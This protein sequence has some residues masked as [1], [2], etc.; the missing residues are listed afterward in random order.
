M[1]PLKI[2]VT[3][4]CVF[5]F[6]ASFSQTIGPEKGKLIIVGGGDTEKITPYFI[7]QAGGENAKIVVIPT[8]SEEE[9]FNDDWYF[10][11]ELKSAGAKNVT[12]VHTRDPKEADTKEFVKPITE[13]TGVWFTGGRQ[14][15]LVDA[16]AG[17]KVVDELWKLL[18]R[19]GII[20]G[21]SAGATIQGSYLARGDSKTNTIMMG[22]HQEGFGFLKDV[23]IDQHVLARNRMFDMFEIIEAHTELLG[24][25]IDESTALVVSNDT[26]KVIGK[27][28]VAVY[29][30]TLY[31]RDTRELQTLPD[32]SQKFFFLREGD[33]YD[34][35][36]RKIIIPER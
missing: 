4:I 34:L 26:M 36:E 11:K 1:K 14:W 30:G 15:R 23:A 25:G 20:G 18:E 9:T 2:S 13:A 21:S 35:M 12:I 3:I 17:T 32:H 22:D 31:K 29:D 19:G 6:S 10:L 5:L 16:Y 28:Y 7:E 24:L 33:Q 8:A 27:S